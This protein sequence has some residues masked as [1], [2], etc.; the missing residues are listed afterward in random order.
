MGHYFVKVPPFDASVTEIRSELDRIRHPFRIAIER[1]RNPFNVGAI[2]RT[3]H[4]F[5]PREIFLVGTA[6]Y[7]EHATMRMDRYENLVELATDEEL[8]ERCR[9]G[10]W[11]I[12]VIEKDGATG[13]LWSSPFPA[14]CVLVFGSEN[15]G[16]SPAVVA[17]AHSVLAIPLYG[18]NH[19]LPLAVAAGI[20]MAEW[21]RRHYAE[22]RIVTARS[23]GE[24]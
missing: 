20:A 9:A 19:S 15:S 7:Y 21:T 4:S 11:P 8:V 6:A 2:I 1:A 17:A 16:V 5:L 3:A 14:D 24:R 13:S 23:G 22:G 18:I 12:V 10:G